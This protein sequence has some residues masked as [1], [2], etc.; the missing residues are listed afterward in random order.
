MTRRGY[1]QYCGLARAIELVGERW[2]LLIVRD[3]LVGPKRYTDLRQ[4]LPRIP[5]NILST[6][7]KELEQGG[8][9][10]RK[11]LPR[12]SGAVVYELTE[13]GADLRRSVTEL[14]RWGA[15]SLGEPREDEIVTTDLLISALQTTFQPAEAAGVSASFELRAG[16]IVLHAVVRDGELEVGE[17]AA[18]DPDLTIGVGPVLRALMDGELAATEA[19]ERELVSL[20]GDTGKLELFTRLFQIEPLPAAQAG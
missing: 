4:G 10:R 14:G 6:R 19:I 3:L 18:D 16:D 7:L 17:G 5:T 8:V 13:Y 20:D 2:A 1:G 15:R 9:V 11:V 12:P